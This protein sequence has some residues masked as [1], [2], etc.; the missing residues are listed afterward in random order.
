MF[1][2]TGEYKGELNA[3]FTIVPPV[4]AYLVKVSVSGKKYTLAWNKGEYAD[5]YQVYYSKKKTGGYKKLYSG[6]DSSA[7]SAKLKSGMYIKIRSYKKAGGK[8][9]YSDWTSAVMIR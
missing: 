1:T 9:Y 4:E 3:E 5:G 6:A 8:V 2:G 7:S